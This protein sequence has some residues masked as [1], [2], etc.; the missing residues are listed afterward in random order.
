[1]NTLLEN[2]K[3][4]N[5]NSNLLQSNIPSN[6]IQT[7]KREYYTLNNPSY[8]RYMVLSVLLLELDKE[9]IRIESI[10]NKR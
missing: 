10:L 4:Y 7:N 8:K 2:G 9:R 1:M 6:S 5:T 3:K